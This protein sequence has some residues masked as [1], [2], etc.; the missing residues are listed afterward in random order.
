ME[1]R[2]GGKTFV[3]EGFIRL[4]AGEN[5]GKAVQTCISLHKPV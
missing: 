1:D 4:D 5:C 2:R 3:A